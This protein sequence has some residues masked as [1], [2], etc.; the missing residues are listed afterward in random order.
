ML[1]HGS[2]KDLI[3]GA[4]RLGRPDSIGDGAHHLRIKPS[5]RYS[6][7]HALFA[8]PRYNRLVD[9][10]L[11]ITAYSLQNHL[12]TKVPSIGQI[13]TNEIYRAVDGHGR[14]FVIPVQTKVGSDKIG[15]AQLF[16]DFAYWRQ[17]CPTLICR[18]LSA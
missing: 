10:F 4:G 16:Q 15:F 11:D 13:E 17:Q 14:Q 8:R 3:L 6:D 1:S 2:R 7:E 12:W 9:T 5:E 18:L